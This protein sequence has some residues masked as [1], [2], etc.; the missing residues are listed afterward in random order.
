MDSGDVDEDGDEDIILGSFTFAFTP[1][2]D[3]LTKSW[4]TNNTDVVI[5]ENKLK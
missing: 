5:L 3:A 4:N 1:V 2:P